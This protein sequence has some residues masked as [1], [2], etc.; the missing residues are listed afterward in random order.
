MALVL[1]SI[2]GYGSVT[3][4]VTMNTLIQMNVP[5]SLRGR[6]FA[7]YLWALQGV[8]PIGSLIIGGSAQ[9]WGVQISMLVS[10]L[11]MLASIGGLHLANPQVRRATA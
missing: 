11:F 2:I 1:I 6:V 7:V 10:A 4:L 3:Q 9:G 5:D 8:A